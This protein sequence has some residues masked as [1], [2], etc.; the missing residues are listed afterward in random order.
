MSVQY[1]NNNKSQK[2]N[3]D[4]VD[5]L[6]SLVALVDIRGVWQQMLNLAIVSFEHL[7]QANFLMHGSICRAP[8]IF[9]T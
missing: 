3:S 1:V 9:S 6:N 2:T 7:Q 5:I 4:L 8:L